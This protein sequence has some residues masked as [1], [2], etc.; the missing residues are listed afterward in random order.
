MDIPKTKDPEERLD[1]YRG[2]I[3]SGA[4]EIEK[5][6]GWRLR[7][8]FF[9]KSTPQAA[10]FYGVILNANYFNFER[11]ISLYQKIPYFRKLKNYS[12]IL[13]SLRFIQKL[14]NELAHWELLYGSST[15]ESVIIYDPIT[16]K[17][18]KINKKVI[19][20]FVVNDKRLLASFGWRHELERKYGIKNRNILSR[21]TTQIREIARLLSKY[22]FFKN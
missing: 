11:K 15:N 7:T 20:E 22:P 16:F 21:R 17:K 1:W 13:N 6:L 10:L 18:R 12:K 14:R 9:S 19:E 8:Y 3:L 2:K 4:T 5:A